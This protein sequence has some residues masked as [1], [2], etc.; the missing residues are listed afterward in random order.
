M[1]TITLSLGALIHENKVLLIKREKPPFMGMWCLPGG[2]LKYGEHADE[3]AVREFKEE[4]DIDT[5][6]NE[7]RGVVSE[8]V[9]EDDNSMHFLM[10]LCT[11]NSKGSVEF[12][13]SREGELKW[14]DLDKLGDKKDIIVGSDIEMITKLV[15]KQGEKKVH[16][17]IMRKK[18]DTY[19]LERFGAE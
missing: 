19:I 16:K 11:L 12:K 18:G 15:L 9:H 4:T 14:F 17:S 10:F 7:L 2:K 8:M 1:K 5:D 13:E 3:C 6:F